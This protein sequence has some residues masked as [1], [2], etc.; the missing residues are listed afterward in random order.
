MAPD[1]EDCTIQSALN[2]FQNNATV[3]QMTG[4]EF[5]DIDFKNHMRSCIEL[6]KEKLCWTFILL[7]YLCVD[8]GV[9][10]R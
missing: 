10:S 9:V 3:L 5:G 1:H 4:G 2:W 8:M 7:C 6:V